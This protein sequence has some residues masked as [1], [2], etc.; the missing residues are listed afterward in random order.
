[1]THLNSY[2]EAY[3]YYAPLYRKHWAIS[4]HEARLAVIRDINETLKLHE[5]SPYVGKLYAELDAVRDAEAAYAKRR[6]RKV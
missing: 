3:A 1:M 4:R 6:A 2:E 5:R